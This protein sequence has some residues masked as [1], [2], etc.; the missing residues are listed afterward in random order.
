MN[1]TC[2]KNWNLPSSG[3]DVTFVSRL[4]CYFTNTRTPNQS[5]NNKIYETIEI[6]KLS[7]WLIL[8]SVTPI[9]PLCCLLIQLRNTFS[10]SI[11]KLYEQWLSSCSHCS[12]I[13]ILELKPSEEKKRRIHTIKMHVLYVVHKKCAC[14]FWCLNLLCGLFAIRR[15]FTA[16]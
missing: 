12:G 7:C 16:Q 14:L 2:L 3:D 11:T 13:N 1:E 6:R 9:I 8:F 15:M 10:K 5:A 4:L